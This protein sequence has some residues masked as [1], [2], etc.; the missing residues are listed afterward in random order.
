MEPKPVMQQ[1][2]QQTQLNK[3]Y[4]TSVGGLVSDVLIRQDLFVGLL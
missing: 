2:Q 1:Q 4:A 3:E